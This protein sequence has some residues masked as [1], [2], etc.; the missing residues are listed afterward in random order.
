MP[1]A[2]NHAKNDILRARQTSGATV[3]DT[4]RAMT[5]EGYIP[6]PHNDTSDVPYGYCQCGCGEM[7][8]II[9]SSHSARGL[10]KGEPRKYVRGHNGHSEAFLKAARTR[11][12]QPLDPPV[13]SKSEQCWLIPLHSQAR[14]GLFAKVDEEDLALVKNYRWYPTTSKRS[15]TYAYVMIGRRSIRMHRMIMGHPVEDVDHING[16]SLDNRRANLRTCEPF[17]NVANRHKLAENKT[18]KFKGVSLR[19]HNGGKWTAAITANGKATNLGQFASEVDAAR[20][21]D[22]AAIDAFGEFAATNEKLGLFDAAGV[23]GQGDE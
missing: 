5:P 8:K 11:K 2:H 18:S 15:K 7:T 20:A 12:R 14:P 21:Y 10:I 4:P 16:D 9:S 3:L 17:Q 6:M 1:K 19:H 23:K 13:F 22:R